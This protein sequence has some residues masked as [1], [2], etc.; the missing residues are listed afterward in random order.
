MQS[1]RSKKETKQFFELYQIELKSEVMFLKGNEVNM[2]SARTEAKQ[3][4]DPVLHAL[5]KRIEN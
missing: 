1:I 4:I 5:R 2:K 3:T